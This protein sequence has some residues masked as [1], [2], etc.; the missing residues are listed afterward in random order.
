MAFLGRHQGKSG[1][2]IEPHLPPKNGPRPDARPIFFRYPMVQHILNQI[3]ILSH[4]HLPGMPPYYPSNMPLF[5]DGR[6]AKILGDD[7]PCG[8]IRD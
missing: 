7:I 8:R 3:Q 1:T 2:Q 5:E 4:D 6:H